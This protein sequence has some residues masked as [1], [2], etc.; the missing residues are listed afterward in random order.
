MKAVWINWSS[1]NPP[2][3]LAIG[4]CDFIFKEKLAGCGAHASLTQQHSGKRWI[5][6][7]SRLAKATEKRKIDSK[8]PRG[9]VLRLLANTQS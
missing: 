5:P 3:I 2:T 6:L 8:K 9:S 4:F 7:S 1:Q